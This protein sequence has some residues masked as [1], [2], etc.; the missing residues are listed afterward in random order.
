MLAE[1]WRYRQSA[2]LKASIH[3]DGEPQ[4]QQCDIRD[5]IAEVQFSRRKGIAAIHYHAKG[6]LGRVSFT[7]RGRRIDVWQ[8]QDAGAVL[9]VLQLGAQKWGVVTITGPDEFKQLCANL[10]AKH[11]IRIGNPELNV[12][13]QRMQ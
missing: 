11:S 2:P 3:G 7:D 4:L 9:A 1:N 5:F 12:Q 13:P 8:Q 10:A 6:A